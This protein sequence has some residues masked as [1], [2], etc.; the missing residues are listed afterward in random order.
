VDPLQDLFRMQ[1]M[2]CS[3]TSYYSPNFHMSSAQMV[4]FTT[5]VVCYWAQQFCERV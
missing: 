5:R 4:G 1:R 2:K 3:S